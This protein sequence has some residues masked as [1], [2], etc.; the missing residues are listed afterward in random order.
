MHELDEN[1]AIGST[2]DGE[3]KLQKVRVWRV[4]TKTKK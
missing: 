4:V 2:E 1:D 3:A